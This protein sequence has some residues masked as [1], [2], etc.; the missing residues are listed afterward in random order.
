V[1]SA[2]W[3]MMAVND[4]WRDNLREEI[5]KGGSESPCPFCGIPRLQRSDYI[6]CC[7]CGI[8]WLEGETLDKDPRTE[9]MRKQVES[10]VTTA[11]K[12]VKKLEN[13]R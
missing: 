6:R 2:W 12:T 4:P 13:Q 1:L 10:N 3:V 11:T 7:R 5:E 9:R 8:N